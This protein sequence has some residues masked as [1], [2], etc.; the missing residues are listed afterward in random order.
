MPPSA[1]RRLKSPTDRRSARRQVILEAAARLFAS[2]GYSDCDMECVASAAGVAKGT[3]YL[4]FAGKR[5]LFFECVDWGLRQMQQAVRAATESTPDGVERMSRGI[6]AYLAFFD[7]HPE[8]V[9]L[10][11][12][13]RAIFRD[14]KRPTYIEHREVNIGYWRELYG[15][16]VAQGRMRS[17]L[18]VQRMVDTVGSLLYGSMFLNHLIGRTVP[19]EDRYKSLVKILWHGLLTERGRPGDTRRPGAEDKPPAPGAAPRRSRNRR[20]AR[21]RADLF[22]RSTRRSQQPGR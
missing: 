12:Q 3:L 14:R 19:F 10:M 11:I 18:P 13:E 22:G 15:Q 21:N 5:E 9:E 2:Q 7:A 1:S 4:Y 16:L 6:N 17:D 8:Y 20:V